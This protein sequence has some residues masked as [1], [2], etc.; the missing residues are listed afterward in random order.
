MRCCWNVS[1]LRASASCAERSLYVWLFGSSWLACNAFSAPSST[2]P[3]VVLTRCMV[4]DTWS[5]ASC[6][7]FSPLSTVPVALLTLTCRPDSC[8]LPLSSAPTS[9]FENRSVCVRVSLS[10]SDALPTVS[11]ELVISEAS[12][13]LDCLAESMVV[14]ALSSVE[15]V[16]RSCCWTVSSWLM[17]SVRSLMTS[18]C[19]LFML[20]V[21]SPAASFTSFATASATLETK[22]VLI[23]SSIV[24]APVSVIFG[25]IAFSFSLM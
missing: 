24:V 16:S 14:R 19:A 1:C 23:C 11:S 25:A 3:V 12:A 18:L 10:K 17:V 21:V 4:L 5:S 13:M 7:V 8:V 9:V 6:V 2:L 20:P 15:R 22:V